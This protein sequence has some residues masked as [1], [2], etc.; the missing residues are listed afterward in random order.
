MYIVVLC[1]DGIMRMFLMFSEG[2]LHQLEMYTDLILGKAIN[3]IAMRLTNTN[4]GRTK[5]SYRVPFIWNGIIH[6]KI[7][8]NTSECVFAIT[9]KQSI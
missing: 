9:I 1:F 2:Y 7:N 3:C 6:N 5:L 8:P 4:L